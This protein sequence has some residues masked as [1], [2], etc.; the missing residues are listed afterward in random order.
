MALRV[1]WAEP[2]LADLDE[3]A[4]YIARD[5]K[6]YSISF[7]RKIRAAARSLAHFPRRGRIVPEFGDP[8]I[9]E[10]A[11]GN[12]RVIFQI[13]T[14]QVVVLAVVHGARDL[15]VAWKWSQ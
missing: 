3:L 14:T 7:I 10:I 15:F 1:A 6:A 13:Q 12:Y 4:A 5:S 9:R 8:S 11:V 2:A